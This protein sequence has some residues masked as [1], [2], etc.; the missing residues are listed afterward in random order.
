VKKHALIALLS[1]VAVTAILA[2]SKE[3]L[4]NLIQ[5]GNSKAALEKIKAGANV[6][7]AQ[8]D[9]TRPIHWA[10]FKVDYEL[11]QALIAKKADVNTPNEFGSTPLAEAVKLADAKMVKMLLDAG[12]KPDAANLDGETALMLAIKNGDLSNV[13]QL[14]ARGANVNV[15]EKFHNQTPLMYAA[16]AQ[17]NAAQM[18]KMLLAKGADPKSRSLFR[19]WDSQ[20]S[21]E[22]RGQYRPTGGH[23]ALLLAARDG[24]LDCIEPLLAAGASIN[25]P[26]P[27]AVT[28]LMLA[29]D[30]GHSEIAK[31]LLQKG[32][33]PNVWDWW[34][35]TALYIAV[36]RKEAAGGRGPASPGAA[37]GKGPTPAMA[38]VSHMELITMLLD[39]GVDPNA[40]LNFHRP[41]RGGNSGRFGETSL[42]TGCTPLFRAVQGNDLQVIQAL[43]AKGANPNINAMGDTP[44]TLAA[45]A[46]PGGRGGNGGGAN[47]AILDL[48]TQHNADVNAKVTGTKSYSMRIMYRAPANAAL[49]G[50]TALHVAAQQGNVDMVRYLL[51]KGADPNVLDSKGKKP[52][53]LAVSAPPAAAQAKGNA[54]A[55]G[56]PG[57]GRGGPSPQ[58]LAEIRA[59]LEGAT[60]PKSTR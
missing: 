17:R 4:A 24:C 46:G 3:P 16:S 51:A 22:P 29:L 55:K 35:R 48:L 2:Q 9:G 32:A 54:Q 44:F 43:L 26:T 33:N 39:A 60:Q 12:A 56:V 18:V 40:E 37:K 53:D 7:E 28:P 57:A 10:V 13:E 15:V 8:P 47:T 25:T 38:G 14:L 50:M 41:S 27:E 31:L 6:N 52:I 30:N 20:I 58:T 5:Q 11:L 21:S 1:S 36:D 49:E 34:G 45:T 59:L 42:S 19:D 23:T